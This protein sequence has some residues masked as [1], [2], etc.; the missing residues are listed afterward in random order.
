[1][2]RPQMAKQHLVTAELCMGDIANCRVARKRTRIHATAREV[3]AAWL[4]FGRSRIHCAA[5]Q[6]EREPAHRSLDSTGS[7]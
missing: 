1:M 3:A 2:T 4:S 6:S 5:I 7:K